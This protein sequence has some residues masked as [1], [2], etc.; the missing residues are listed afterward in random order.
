MPRW[1]YLFVRCQLHDGR[2]RP[3]LLNAQAVENWEA[4]PDIAAFSNQL[5]AEGWEMVNVAVTGNAQGETTS[6]RAFF[7]R[8]KDATLA[9]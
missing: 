8:P 7:K 1:E 6:F 9:F 2:W 4:G 5:G 3:Y